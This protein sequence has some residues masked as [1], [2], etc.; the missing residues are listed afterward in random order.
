MNSFDSSWQRTKGCG[1]LRKVSQA[2]RVILNGWV[3]GLRE[4]SQQ[5]FVDL[6]DDS[7]IVQLVFSPEV[8]G[9]RKIRYGD[10]I[11]AKGLVRE[12]PEGMTNKNIPTGEL[13]VSVSKF[14]LLASSKTPPFRAGQAVNEDISLKYRYLD[15]RYR[16]DLRN[17]LKKRHQVTRLVRGYFS[18]QGFHEIETPLLYKNTPEGARDYLVA[19]RNQKG[20]FY[21]LPQSPQTLKQIVMIAGLEKYFQI[22]RCFR[23]ED[24]RAD[25]QPEFSQID[26]EM[27]FAV[28]SDIMKVSENL[29]RLLWWEI[30][31]E[32]L[33][34]IPVL[35][36]EDSLSRFGTDK[37]DLRNPL[38]LKTLSRKI[39]ESLGL[40]V[41]SSGLH[42][43][44]AVK[45]L[46]VPCMQLSVSRLK[47]LDAFA[48]S[49][50][51]GGL[52]WISS[53]GKELKSPLAKHLSAEKLKTFF[54]ESGGNGNGVC[55]VSAGKIQT[56]NSVLSDLRN[57][58]AKDLNLIDKSKTAFVW[59]KD[60]PLLEFDSQKKSWSPQ[61]HPFTSPNREGL[62]LLKKG[63]DLS[64]IKARAYDLVCNGQELAS[65]SIRN[66]SVEL[67]MEIFS[68]LG[69][70]EED[71]Q[72][73]FGF[74]LE[75]LGLGCPPHGGI[76]WGLER[77]LMLLMGTDSIRDVIAFPKSASASCLMS[78]APSEADP[79]HLAELGIRIC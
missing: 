33:G 10:V 43:N 15:L 78:G 60:F 12:R 36:Y 25:R 69:L 77:L 51:L 22:C 23:D 55:F 3:R 14:L 8:L 28:E 49:K 7:G 75:A 57:Q 13:E 40:Q 27:S 35:T 68:A 65:G 41:L 61:H 76:A 26:V 71:I 64:L 72:K 48:K 56:I 16:S 59:I 17:L 46:F 34:D 45:A 21:A 37:P 73:R 6:W 54:K 53:D 63:G 39:V 2:E 9:E 50:G 38:Q 62:E 20:S 30:K 79:E 58:F 19:S 24:L 47:R 11:A 66:H 74:F 44:S 1:E 67:Q 18:K 52:L 31:N 32:E 4:H 70:L 42:E 5:L 29:A